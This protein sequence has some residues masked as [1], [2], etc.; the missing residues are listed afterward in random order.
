VLWIF[1]DCINPNE[2][3]N[4][5]TGFFW[6][7]EFPKGSIFCGEKELGDKDEII[8]LIRTTIASKNV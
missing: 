3:V 5:V 8:L 6:R 7:E 4:E 1:E 2:G